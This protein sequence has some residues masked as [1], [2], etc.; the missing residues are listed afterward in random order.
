MVVARREALPIFGKQKS[1]GY[2]KYR[3]AAFFGQTKY[4]VFMGRPEALAFVCPTKNSVVMGR[5]EALPFL[6]QSKNPAIIARPELLPFFGQ[7]KNPVVMAWPEA[8]AFFLTM[9]SVVMGRPEV[10]LFGGGLGAMSS[11]GRGGNDF[12]GNKD[13]Q[14]RT[15]LPCQFKAFN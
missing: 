9:N 11:W 7:T 15:V 5:L 6:G 14:K 12:G 13:G 3:G 4:S 8:L 10:L 2:F 1:S